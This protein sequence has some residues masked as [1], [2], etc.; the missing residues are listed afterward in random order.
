MTHGYRNRLGRCCRWELETC[1]TRNVIRNGPQ[2]RHFQL[3]FE[4]A[5]A[6]RAGTVRHYHYV[7]ANHFLRPVCVGLK[8]QPLL[9]LL[10]LAVLHNSLLRHAEKRIFGG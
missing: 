10:L 7:D 8:N 9:L 6:A 2:E 1:G 4:R 5:H 3:Q